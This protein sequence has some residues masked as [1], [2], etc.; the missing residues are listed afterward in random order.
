MTTEILIKKLSLVQD[1]LELMEIDFITG[2]KGSLEHHHQQFERFKGMEIVL[3]SLLGRIQEE[4]LKEKDF[5]S[6]RHK[7]R[8]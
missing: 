3:L 8:N 2:D 4:T 6:F 1:T 5:T 7:I